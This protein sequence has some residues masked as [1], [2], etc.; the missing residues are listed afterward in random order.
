[1]SRHDSEYRPMRTWKDDAVMDMLTKRRGEYGNCNLLDAVPKV[2][3]MSSLHLQN[4][5]QLMEVIF[6]HPDNLGDGLA[7]F[8]GVAF[9]PEAG[10][11]WRMTARTNY[12][13]LVT[14][15]Q[16]PVFADDTPVA[17]FNSTNFHPRQQV[18]LPSV[19]KT[20]NNPV[21][22]AAAQVRIIG[23]T[24]ERWE[25]EVDGSAAAWV[26]VAQNYYPVWQAR[27]DGETTALWRANHAFQALCVPKGKHRVVLVYRDVAFR[28]GAGIS[29]AALALSLGGLWINRR[30]TVTA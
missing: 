13:P 21:T 28:L 24:A 12:L 11:I 10:G 3:S 16:Q 27:V 15:G 18:F 23:V 9:K 7:D 17:F 22:A 5:Q 14:A 30:R 1:M 25:F 8:L 26:V 20:G 29:L 4:M 6:E 19:A 2:N